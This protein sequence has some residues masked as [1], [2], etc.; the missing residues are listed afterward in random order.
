[1][2]QQSQQTQD[3]N[4]AVFPDEKNTPIVEEARRTGQG[5]RKSDAK[6]G[7]EAE[8]PGDKNTDT[9]GDPNQGTEAR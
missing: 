6:S 2:T 9:P 4:N 8:A 7:A 3:K 5:A 1:M